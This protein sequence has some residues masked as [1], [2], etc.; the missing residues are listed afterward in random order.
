MSIKIV[1]YEAGCYHIGDYICKAI[2]LDKDGLERLT[3]VREYMNIIALKIDYSKLILS[4]QYN[5]GY[6]AYESVNPIGSRV[7]LTCFAGGPENV[8]FT[9]KFGKASSDVNSLQNYPEDGDITVEKYANLITNE[10]NW[11]FRYSYLSFQINDTYDNYSYVCVATVNNQ[12]T[13]VGRMTIHAKKS[14]LNPIVIEEGNQFSVKCDSSLAGVPT[15]YASVVSLEITWTNGTEEPIT[16]AN[17]SL[18]PQP[19]NFSFTPNSRHWKFNFKSGITGPSVEIDVD[20]AMCSDAGWYLC[21]ATYIDDSSNSEVLTS[22]NQ[23]VA[24][25]PRAV[26]VSLTLVPQ[27]NEGL[28]PFESVNPAGSNVVLTCNV[29]GRKE[30]SINWKFGNSSNNVYSISLYLATSDTTD[31]EPVQISSGTACVQYLHSSTLNF[32]TEQKFSG[33]MYMCEATSNSEVI[34]VGNMT[35]QVTSTPESTTPAVNVYSKDIVSTSVI[36]EGGT[37]TVTCDASRAGVPP[38][39]STVSNLFIGWTNGTT[40]PIIYAEY[41]TFIKPYNTLYPPLTSPPRNWTFIFSGNQQN[42]SDKPNNRDTMKILITVYD[43][44]KADE[45]IYFCN[46]SYLD[47]NDHETTAYKSQRVKNETTTET[48]DYSFLY[49]V[50]PVAA[51]VVVVGVVIATVCFVKVRRDRARKR[52]FDLRTLPAIRAVSVSPPMDSSGYLLPVDPNGGYA[53]ISDVAIYESSA[54]YYSS[55]N[56]LE[57]IKESDEQSENTNGLELYQEGDMD[58]LSGRDT[59]E[60]VQVDTK[61]DGQLDTKRDGQLDIKADT[62]MA[63]KTRKQ[64]DIQTNVQPDTKTDKDLDKDRQNDSTP[65]DDLNDYTKLYDTPENVYSPDVNKYSTPNFESVI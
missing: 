43:A 13:T 45:G 10:C 51:V 1:F 5:E 4:P 6:G 58:T 17:Y 3:E 47:E 35:I 33:Y 32:T 65:A 29:T 40:P 21:T 52:R 9:W 57:F 30:L 24:S 20:D 60:D 16:Y 41:R 54:N 27:Y 8:N 61:R 59:N 7:T 36:V 49:Y 50:I 23:S 37:F 22:Q 26:P 56:E 15:S 28:G 25:L 63:I 12:D 14:I 53:Q 39:I 38:N 2:Y 62:L 31:F 34:Y 46:A 19:N 44:N 11:Y 48:S 55:I 42:T 64:L 18:L